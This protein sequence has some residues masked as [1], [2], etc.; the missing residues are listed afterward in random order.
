MG[1]GQ[2]QGWDSEGTGMGQLLLLLL[3]P[4]PLGAPAQAGGCEGGAGEIH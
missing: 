4:G 1:T 2:R 3:F